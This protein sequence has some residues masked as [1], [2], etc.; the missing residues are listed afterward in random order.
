MRVVGEIQNPDCK[1]TIFSWNNKY[2][3][4]MERGLIEQTYKVPEMEVTGDEDIQKIVDSLL[5]KAVARFDEMEQ[6]LGEALE[7]LY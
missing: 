3:V 2:L 7:S 4:K 1:I 6:E 5:P